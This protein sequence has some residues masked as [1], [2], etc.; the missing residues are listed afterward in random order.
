MTVIPLRKRRRKKV[1]ESPKHV[2]NS[3]PGAGWGNCM[4]C[5]GS[6]FNKERTVRC[7]PCYGSGKVWFEADGSVS[8]HEEE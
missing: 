7:I 3:P 1:Q 2:F 4:R 5:G 8:I 6:G